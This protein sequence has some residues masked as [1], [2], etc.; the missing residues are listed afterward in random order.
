MNS[1]YGRH[2]T[3]DDD[4][5]DPAHVATMDQQHAMFRDFVKHLAQHC[6]DALAQGFPAQ[7]VAL[8]MA[9]ELDGSDHTRETFA[10][11]LGIALTD[12]ARSSA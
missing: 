3:P 4:P 9:S 10:C 2:A 6:R 12:L 1:Y 8:Q 11:L 7:A 5:R